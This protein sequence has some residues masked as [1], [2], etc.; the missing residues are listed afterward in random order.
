MKLSHP[1]LFSSLLTL[2]FSTG[3]PPVAHRAADNAQ[4]LVKLPEP[5]YDSKTSVEKALHDR[6]SL[7][8]YKNLA[9]TL[10]DLSQLLWAAQGISGSGGRRTAPSAGA[11]YPLE[12]YVIAGNVTGLSNGVYSYDP[13]KHALSRV[14]ES[15][16]R[17]ELSRAALGQSSI[18]KA[19]AILVISAVYERV[20]VKYGERGIR[21]AHMEAGHAAENVFL[22]AV[23]LELGTVVIGAFHDEEVKA[24][25]HLRGQ[26]EPLYLMPV[27]KK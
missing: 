2:F 25:L 13:H 23:S 18:Q 22:Q 21:Y 24:V 16:T 9:I 5:I 19:A 6:R 15:D 11:L 12:L 17:V 26:E 3:A 20:T 4:D 1:F 27:G 7:R 8:S 10:Q 14:L